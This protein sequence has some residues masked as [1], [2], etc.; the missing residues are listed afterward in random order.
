MKVSVGLRSLRVG[1][2]AVAA[3][4]VGGIAFATIPDASGVIHV[5][6]MKSGGALR[7]IDDG[8]T[9]CKQG[10]TALEWNVQGVP[11]PPGPPGAPGEPGPPGPPGVSLFANVTQSG[12]LTNGTATGAS[13]TSTG[14]YKV[15]FGQDVSTCA[16][17]ATAGSTG[18]GASFLGAW[19]NTFVGFTPNEVE[20]RFNRQDSPVTPVDTDFHLIVVC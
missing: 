13:R 11:G 16:P 2:A 9:N 5:C 7:V 18:S 3:L 19:S 8:V 4:V 20:V 15:T 12:T 14:F 1:L 17:V 10:E 6:Y